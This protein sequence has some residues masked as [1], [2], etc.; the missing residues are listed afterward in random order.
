[1]VANLTEEQHEKLHRDKE[2]LAKTGCKPHN[3]PTWKI[4]GVPNGKVCEHDK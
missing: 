1:M 4:P 3:V 2:L